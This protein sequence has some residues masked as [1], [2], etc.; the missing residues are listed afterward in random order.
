MGPYSPSTKRRCAYHPFTDTKTLLF[1]TYKER[2]KKLQPHQDSNSGHKVQRQACYSITV[3]PSGFFFDNKYVDLLKKDS[4][5]ENFRAL[6]KSLTYHVGNYLNST[7]LY[8]A[9]LINFLSLMPVNLQDTK[10]SRQHVSWLSIEER[11]WKISDLSKL[12]ES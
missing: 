12:P 2:M 1:R 5:R 3:T 4:M 6:H 7:H 11:R 10:S 8:S 9:Y